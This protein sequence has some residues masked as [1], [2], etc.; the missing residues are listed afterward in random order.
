MMAN[1]AGLTVANNI[2]HTDA[3]RVVQGNK[4]GFYKMEH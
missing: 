1:F 4:T 2:Q 3:E